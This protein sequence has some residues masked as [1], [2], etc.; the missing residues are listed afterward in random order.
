VALIT[1]RLTDTAP[2]V[3]GDA[4]RYAGAAA[5]V[6]L[7]AAALIGLVSSSAASASEE[8]LA[9]SPPDYAE[10]REQARKAERWAPWSSEPWQRLGEAQLAANDV[11][12]ARESFRRAIDKEPTDWELWFRLAEASTGPARLRALAEAERLNPRSPELEALRQEGG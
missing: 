1:L 3:P 2:V 9:A 11:V 10:A 6:A 12:G 4:A 5:A 8:A 7:A